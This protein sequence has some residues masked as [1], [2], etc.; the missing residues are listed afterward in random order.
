MCG[1]SCL[2][3]SSD[4][5]PASGSSDLKPPSAMAALDRA[6]ALRPRACNSMHRGYGSLR[7][8]ESARRTIRRPPRGG[9]L[10]L[11]EE[12]LELRLLADVR[13]VVVVLG[14]AADVVGCEL[15]RLR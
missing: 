2:R 6:S 15:H 9:R 11:G 5:S 3:S 1:S 10:Q 13:K 14:V 12:L 7:C 8:V 4:T